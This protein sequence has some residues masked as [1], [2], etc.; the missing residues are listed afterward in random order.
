MAVPATLAAEISEREV[1]DPVFVSLDPAPTSV[2][3]L[4]GKVT[5]MESDA[6][7]PLSNE[8]L[9]MIVEN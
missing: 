7:K 1:V 8:N 3:T 6:P 5:T 2:A 9:K 4:N